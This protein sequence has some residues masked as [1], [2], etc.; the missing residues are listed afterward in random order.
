MAP[1]LARHQ[2][3]NLSAM[4]ACQLQALS[5]S[6]GN[7]GKLHE[8]GLSEAV[9]GRQDG[10][11]T[12][13]PKRSDAST[14]YVQ[15]H[16]WQP[17]TSAADMISSGLRTVTAADSAA[18]PKADK[19]AAGCASHTFGSWRCQLPGPGFVVL[20]FHAAR[21]F[22][23]FFGCL[24]TTTQPAVGATCCTCYA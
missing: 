23:V 24:A 19:T 5:C 12:H 7:L 11:V 3:T 8:C 15:W 4:V 6:A 9:G 13:S 2:Q 14:K 20:G 1:R 10:A 21:S 17:T 22:K 18:E 16:A